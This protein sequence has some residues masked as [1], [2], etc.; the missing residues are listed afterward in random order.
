[1][2][3]SKLNQ[4]LRESNYEGPQLRHSNLGLIKF[5]ALGGFWS[6]R[7]KAPSD[8]PTLTEYYIVQPRLA[9]ELGPPQASE[10]KISSSGPLLA[11]AEL[12]SLLIL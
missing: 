6:F 5:F 11:T 9:V 12:Q 3:Q 8:W 2:Q 1:M 10:D 4:I 7:L